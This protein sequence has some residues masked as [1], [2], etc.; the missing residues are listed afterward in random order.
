MFGTGNLEVHI[1][2]VVFHTLDIG[3]HGVFA[4]VFIHDQTHGHTGYRSL[5]GHAGSHQRHGAC[6]DGSLGRRTIGFCDIRNSP[7]SIWKFF[8][9]RKNLSQGSFT[10]RAMTDFTASGA[11]HSAGLAYRIGRE[12]VVVHP[13]LV[14]HFSDVINDLVFIESAQRGAG[15]NLGFTA[16][17]HGGTMH[18]GQQVNLGIQRTDFIHGSS[19][20]TNL[21]LNDQSSDFIRLNGTADLAYLLEGFSLFLFRSVFHGFI[22]SS[23]LFNQSVDG[24]IA[25]E[26]LLNGNC[27]ADSG[28]IFILNG[29]FQF[30][31]KG[32]Q[33]NFAF[34]FAHSGD[35]G[36]LESA[37]L[38]NSGVSKHQSLEHHFFR[39][40][41]GAG[42]HHV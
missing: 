1:A 26:L 37:Q 25:F 38:L 34:G 36:F 39:N 22:L 40:F 8:H 18:A 16:G 32:I 30:R 3:Q 2:E 12:V 20:R 23:G 35:D 17:E 9:G 41:F 4:A 24:F 5:Y 6:A 11:A 31:I 19:V 29:L 13:A 21:V 14:F 42:F 33:G 15:N 10:Q 28:F 27:F 7:D